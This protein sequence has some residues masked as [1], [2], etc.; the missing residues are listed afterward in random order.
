MYANTCIRIVFITCLING[1]KVASTNINATE[2]SA[3]RFDLPSF[4]SCGRYNFLDPQ[5]F[6]IVSVQN[7]SQC[8]IS[9]TYRIRATCKAN[10]DGTVVLGVYKI[11]KT[12]D[13]GIYM[14]RGPQA[15]E[16][17]RGFHVTVTGAQRPSFEESLNPGV[18][19]E[20]ESWSTCNVSCFRTRTRQC[21]G[22]GVCVGGTGQEMATCTDHGK[23]GAQTDSITWSTWS[24]WGECSCEHSQRMRHRYCLDDNR[25]QVQ[26]PLRTIGS[27]EKEQCQPENCPNSRTDTVSM[28]P[29]THWG[30]WSPWTQCSRTCAE[31][32]QSRSRSCLSESSQLLPNTQCIGNAVETRA[33]QIAECSGPQDQ[34]KQDKAITVT[35]PLS[36]IVGLV[37]GIVILIL[38][39][40]VVILLVQLKCKKKRETGT[41]HK[42]VK[43]K[44]KNNPDQRKE[45]SISGVHTYA[46]I[47]EDDVI[48]LKSETSSHS[49]A[50]SIYVPL[51]QSPS[52]SYPTQ[53]KNI[54]YNSGTQSIILGQVPENNEVAHV[55]EIGSNLT[56]STEAPKTT[57]RFESRHVSLD[58]IGY[59]KP[60]TKWFKKPV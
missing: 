57:T 30:Y 26:C 56:T 9:E 35:I 29:N 55:S 58:S 48:D 51:P 2:G 42:N 6:E 1:R 24:A 10:E 40:V 60:K 20:W 25:Q 31:G 38:V 5:S 54:T 16:C 13:A 49:R 3:V 45:S 18:W 8:K 15:P 43:N 37:A 23:C 32:Q 50:E 28:T 21:S 7:T 12:V 46:E 53:Y 19:L 41:K 44:K 34:A 14:I 11:N 59:M 22:N 47:D 27:N 33:C 52:G 36:M 39:I 4:R 17:L